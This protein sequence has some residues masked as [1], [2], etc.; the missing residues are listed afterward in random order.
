MVRMELCPECASKLVYPV[1]WREVPYSDEWKIELRCPDC[2]WGVRSNFAHE[3]VE[4]FDSVL[5][6]G[7]DKLIHDCEQLSASNMRDYID[8]F[9]D[10]LQDDHILPEDF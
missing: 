7:T 8:R 4:R 6:H 5:N 10:A 9:Q 2:E 1:M 3:A